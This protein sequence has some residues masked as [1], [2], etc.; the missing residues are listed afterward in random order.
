MALRD[1]TPAA[2]ACGIGDC[3]GVWLEDDGQHLQII[4]RMIEPGE[5]AGRIGE[6]EAVIRIDRALLANVL[7]EPGGGN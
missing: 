5:L 6:G 3:P 1:L 7:L 4:G 2:L